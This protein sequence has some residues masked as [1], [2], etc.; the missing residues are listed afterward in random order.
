VRAAVGS[1]RRP[2]TAAETPIRHAAAERATLQAVQERGGSLPPAPALVVLDDILATLERLHAAGITHSHIRPAV[3]VV[4]RDG[5]CRL[6]DGNPPPSPGSAASGLLGYVAPE[7]R[8]GRAVTPQADVYSATSVFLEALTNLPPLGGVDQARR[9]V[10]VP[11]AARGLL[12]EG[13][14]PD[15]RRRPASPGRLRADIAV[16]GDAFLEDDWRGRGRAWL[17]AAAGAIETGTDLA[18]AVQSPWARPRRP[19]GDLP[20]PSDARP[21]KPSIGL[22]S[23]GAAGAAGASAGASRPTSP[24]S[25]PVADSLR[26]AADS[27]RPT[28]NSRPTEYSRPTAPSSR[29]TGSA[30]R[31]VVASSRPTP[32]SS[33]PTQ[34][35]SRP[36]TTSSRSGAASSQPAPR[37]LS[38]ALRHRGAGAALA[39]ETATPQTDERGGRRRP[40]QRVIAGVALGTAGLVALVLVAALILHGTPATLPAHQP[41]PATAAPTALPSP[42]QPVFGFSQQFATPAPATPSPSPSPT[43][44]ATPAVLPGTGAPPASANQPPPPAQT[45]TAPPVNCFVILFCHTG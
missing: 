37:T 21:A 40:D 29:Q 30:E 35:S 36:A 16:A 17:S 31:P 12:E 24:S 8:A 14:H 9:D 42:S 38:E 23:A 41:V 4:G 32:A 19:E 7:V 26:S 1:R 10:S 5:R 15:P 13:L 6:N 27:S 28:E 25:R 34:S 18:G 11:M 3:V 44:S 33:R 43:P 2:A 20:A 39:S 22:G 45:Q